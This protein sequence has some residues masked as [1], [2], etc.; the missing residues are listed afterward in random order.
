MPYIFARGEPGLAIEIY[1]VDKPE[2][3][4]LVTHTLRLA[5]DRPSWAAHFSGGDQAA[6]R[7]FLGQSSGDAF[8]KYRPS[9]D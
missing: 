8:S 3:S 2:I 6:I 4:E 5:F 7:S 9:P 1:T